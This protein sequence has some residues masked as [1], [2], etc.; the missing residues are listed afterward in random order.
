MIKPYLF[1]QI[2]CENIASL[3]SVRLQSFI[4]IS[5]VK[6]AFVIKVIQRNAVAP[7][8]CPCLLYVKFPCQNSTSVTVTQWKCRNLKPLEMWSDA[9]ELILMTW[10]YVASLS[11]TALLQIMFSSIAKCDIMRVVDALIYISESN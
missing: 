7:S 4:F 1:F 3:Q 9:C 11:Y 10:W 5:S 8:Q 6:F 2:I